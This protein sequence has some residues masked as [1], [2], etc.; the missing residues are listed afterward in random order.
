[1]NKSSKRLALTAWSAG[2]LLLLSGCVRLDSS[3]NPIGTVWELLGKP[4][5]HVITYFAKD[6]GLGFGLGIILVTI[7]VRLIILPL[8]LHQSR[9]AAYQAAKRDYLKPI[10]DPINERMKNATTQ[11]EKLAAQT[12][13]MQAQRENG[14]SML[15][16][17]GCLPLL[18]QMPFFSALYFAARF[19]KGVSESTFLGINL[20]ERSLILIAIIALLYFVQSYLS[21]LSMPEEQRSQMKT[22]TYTMPLVM[23]FMA[24]SLPSSVGL[25]WFVGGIFS[26]IQQLITTYLIKP[27]LRKKVEE[28]FKNNPPKAFKSTNTRK[29]VTPKQGKKAINQPKPKANRNAGKQRKRK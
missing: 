25:Y 27:G 6:L 4:M 2:M 28:E 23:V 11:E 8:G 13:L 22:M 9:K 18:I 16:G 5:S 10:F 12:E 15:G 1:M 24:W 21:M 19:T 3:G 29:D 7:V 20:G 14:V 26:I 17:L